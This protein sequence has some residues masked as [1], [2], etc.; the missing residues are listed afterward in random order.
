M[1]EVTKISDINAVCP[2]C[3]ANQNVIWWEFEGIPIVKSLIK[4][5][6]CNEFFYHNFKNEFSEK[7]VIKKQFYE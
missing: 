5:F 2:Y 3:G 6:Y 7:V 4:C 1:S